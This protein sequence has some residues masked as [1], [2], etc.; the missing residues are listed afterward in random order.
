ME[1]LNKLLQEKNAKVITDLKANVQKNIKENVELSFNNEEEASAAI[2]LLEKIV[3]LAFDRVNVEEEE[4]ELTEE[5]KAELAE[6]LTEKVTPLP[7][8]LAGL[9]ANPEE[10][11][12]DEI[13]GILEAAK[14]KE[15]SDSVASLNE[16][17]EGAGID[18]VMTSEELLKAQELVHPKVFEQA[19]AGETEQ[20][21]TISKLFTKPEVVEEGTEEGTEEGVEEAVDATGRI[22]AILTKKGFT[23]EEIEENVKECEKQVEIF[24]KRKEEAGVSGTQLEEDVTNFENALIST[25]EQFTK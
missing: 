17:L 5:V 24:R 16:K 21:A 3:N 19:L 12:E 14:A 22:T 7:T 15:I 10:P 9:F 4:V 1:K 20:L 11:S 18:L 25:T 8:S 6:N 2:E 13:N 23:P